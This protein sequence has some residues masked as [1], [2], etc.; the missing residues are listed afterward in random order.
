MKKLY[1]VNE[2]ERRLFDLA[3]TGNIDA[4]TNYYLKGPN[5][6]TWWLPGAQTQVWS[7]GYARLHKYWLGHD[8]PDGFEYESKRYT[9]VGNHE[10]S[11]DFP[12]DPA[13]HHNHGF[14]LL[15]QFKDLFADRTNIRTVIAGWGSGKT[16]NMAV[17]LLVYAVIYEDFRGF[18]LGPEA[19][20]SNEFL[21]I[22]WQV[23]QG[24]LFFERFY[25]HYT[26]GPNAILRLGNSIVGET[27]IESYP[28]KGREDSLLTLT[29]DCAVIDQAEKFDALE[30]A[31]KGVG[32]RFRGRV[33]RTGRERIGTLTLLANS[34]YND[35]LWQVFDKGEE[36]PDNYLSMSFG[37]YDNPYLTDKD[38]VR[39]EL[40]AGETQEDRRVHLL[41]GRP[42]GEGKEFGRDVIL[43]MSDSDLDEEMDTQV[44]V[45]Q[46]GYTKV[47]KKG[48]GVVEWLLPYKEKHKYLVISD[49]GTD[50]PPKRNA[51]GIMVWDYTQFP[52]EPATLAG[53]VWGFGKGDILN[54]ANKHA[55][56]TWR[57]HAIGSNGFD[58]TG[59]QSGYDHWMQILNNLL[60]EKINLGGNNKSDCLN[61]AKMLSAAGRMRVPSSIRP[62]WSQLQR[63]EYPEPQGL[64]QDLVM[65]YIM[66]CWWL[67]RIYYLGPQHEDDYTPLEGNYGED[68]YARP[69]EDRSE[70]SYQ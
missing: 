47:E 62:I 31:L 46:K 57:Y 67:K 56:L 12:D 1:E 44:A 6:G 38:I 45:G 66:S 10:M 35:A 49:P 25:R 3:K 69:L 28:L 15:P 30:E 34:D 48:A 55:E 53:F 23:I 40:L 27:S 9:V 14:I 20:Q 65:V 63:Y 51:Y 5:T 24:T 33:V 22:A 13:F 50:N 16:L 4:F 70:V 17:I 36:D 59:Y 52:M 64:R 60:S 11:R 26:A 8:R 42:I 39:Y 61:S 18:S 32:S 7:R 37:S 41:G 19:K 21:K 58:A 29:G 68:R 2:Q 43:R 54:W